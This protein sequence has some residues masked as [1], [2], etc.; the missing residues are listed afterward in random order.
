MMNVPEKILVLCWLSYTQLNTFVTQAYSIVPN[1]K[2]IH[3]PLMFIPS[4]YNYS[5]YFTNIPKL[6][7]YDNMYNFN[8]LYTNK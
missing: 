6:S 5:I 1:I 3:L 8:N 2:K 7:P 4:L